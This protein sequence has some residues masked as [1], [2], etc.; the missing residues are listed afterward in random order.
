MSWLLDDILGST[1]AVLGYKR[2]PQTALTKE[3]CTFW[4][5][6]GARFL[7]VLPSEAEDPDEG[8]IVDST[9]ELAALFVRGE[10][11][12][13]VVR[14]DRSCAAQFSSGEAE[15]VVLAFRKLLHVD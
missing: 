2:N 9:G 6:L 12:F 8:E 4:N 13:L 7:C 1:F 10:G 11:D 15:D 5:Q 3:A 14:P